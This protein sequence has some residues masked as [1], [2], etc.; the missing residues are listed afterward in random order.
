MRT[1]GPLVTGLGAPCQAI[2]AARR[3]AP[4][5]TVNLTCFCTQSV[6]LVAYLKVSLEDASSWT[7][8]WLLDCGAKLR[9][10]ALTVCGSSLVLVTETS[11]VW[12]EPGVPAMST[13][14]VL[15]TTV[16]APSVPSPSS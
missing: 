5:G 9:V 10:A 11:V 13:W 12:V 8:C 15:T 1:T 16:L 7:V 3:S 4:A 2:E 14:P 6:P